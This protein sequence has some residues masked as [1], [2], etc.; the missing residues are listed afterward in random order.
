MADEK[1]IAAII[2][3]RFNRRLIILKI[4]YDEAYS[5]YSPG[6]KL[7]ELMLKKTFDS[8]EID[9]VDC[10]TRYRW[11]AGW[12]MENREYCDI[13]IYP[14][15]GIPPLTGYTYEKLCDCGRRIKI[16]RE[17]SHRLQGGRQNPDDKL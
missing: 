17:L 4:A 11:N 13:S 2:A 1:A 6:D 15:Q 12:N 9:E 14:K 7:F 8:T 16:F 5:S 3:I 10:L